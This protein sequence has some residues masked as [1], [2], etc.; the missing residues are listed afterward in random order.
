[1]RLKQIKS[2]EKEAEAIKDTCGSRGYTRKL[3]W[4]L[5]EARVIEAKASALEK[6]GSA[7]AKSIGNNC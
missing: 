6:E 3:Q 7:K 2:F 1:L 5:P 4:G